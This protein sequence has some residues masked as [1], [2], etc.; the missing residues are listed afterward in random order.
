MQCSIRH[1]V[2]DIP[3]SRCHFCCQGGKKSSRHD[4]LS[5][6]AQK[7]EWARWKD[8]IGMRSMNTV[9]PKEWC[10]QG[11]KLLRDGWIWMWWEVK[12]SRSASH[13]TARELVWED[14]TPFQGCWGGCRLIEIS[15]EGNWGGKTGVSHLSG[16][17]DLKK[18]DN[19]KGGS[20]TTWTKMWREIWDGGGWE[21]EDFVYLRENI[22]SVL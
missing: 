21:E 15:K 5:T 14:L 3:K 8:R 1:P 4:I 6:E 11:M 20:A 16:R 22:S 19:Q 12:L 17:W 13:Q 2:S 18:R 10:S 9:M 7:K